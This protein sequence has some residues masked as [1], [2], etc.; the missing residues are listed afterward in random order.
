MLPMRDE[1]SSGMGE[2]IDELSEWVSHIKPADAPGLVGG[3]ILNRHLRS[4]HATEGF[5]YIVNFNRELWNRCSGSTLSEHA[6]LHSHHFLRT[7]GPNPAE[8]HHQI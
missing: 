5:F 1:N 6:D 3:S 8:I 2:D 7:V 4:A